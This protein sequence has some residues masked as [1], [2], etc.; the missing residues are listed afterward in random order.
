MY[1][2]CYFYVLKVI[3]YFTLLLENVI[4]YCIK[5]TR[6]VLLPNTMFTVYKET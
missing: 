2:N 1:E 4:C 6:N 3:N 5:I